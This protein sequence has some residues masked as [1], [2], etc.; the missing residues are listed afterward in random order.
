MKKPRVWEYNPPSKA[1][2]IADYQEEI[3]E[4]KKEIGVLVHALDE[5]SVRLSW[6]VGRLHEARVELHAT[7][8]KL[9]RFVVRYEEALSKLEQVR[10]ICDYLE[11]R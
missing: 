7:R 5:K 4:L 11:D 1:A 10:Q 3:E 2:R 6:T 8:G 9:D